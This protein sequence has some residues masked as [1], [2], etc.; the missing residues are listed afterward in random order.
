MCWAFW[1]T[2]W[3]Q[4]TQCCTGIDSRLSF[5]LCVCVYLCHGQRLNYNLDW[6]MRKCWSDFRSLYVSH[7]HT[8]TQMT[9]AGGVTWLPNSEAEHKDRSAQGRL[10]TA[11]THAHTHRHTHTHTHTMYTSTQSGSR[12]PDPWRQEN[13]MDWVVGGWASLGARVGVLAWS[14]RRSDIWTWNLTHTWPLWDSTT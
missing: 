1:R 7:T 10:S 14:Q 11:E 3:W 6:R 5:H 12:C 4:S 2:W 8:N 9:A 13:R